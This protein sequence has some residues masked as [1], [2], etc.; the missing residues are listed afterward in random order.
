MS[1]TSLKLLVCGVPSDP[2]TYVSPLWQASNEEYLPSQQ[3]LY[4]HGA[5]LEDDSAC[6]GDVGIAP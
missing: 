2:V 4:Y 5:E 3:R 1:A 6:L